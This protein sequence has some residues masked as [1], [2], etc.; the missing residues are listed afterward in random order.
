MPRRCKKL[1]CALRQK[2]P[3]KLDFDR[4]SQRRH[5]GGEQHLNVMTF[6]AVLSTDIA[7]PEE[8]WLPARVRRHGRALEVADEEQATPAVEPSRTDALQAWL[9]RCAAQPLNT[10]SDAD[11][12]DLRW[13]G[14]KE[15]YAL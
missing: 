6:T 12:D 15:K 2:S 1:R 5:F 11:L 14:L 9:H 8:T 10:F 7:L 3:S 4:S 13:Q